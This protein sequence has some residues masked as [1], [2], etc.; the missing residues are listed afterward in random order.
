M[1]KKGERKGLKTHGPFGKVVRRRAGQVRRRVLR[2]L[3]EE[4]K[5]I[6]LRKLAKTVLE[7][8]FTQSERGAGSWS[9]LAKREPEML[10]S[11]H[12]ILKSSKRVGIDCHGVVSLARTNKS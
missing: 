7:E 3:E 8:I 10:A 1:R 6:K 5:P 4:G 11:L 2:E 9:S 12:S